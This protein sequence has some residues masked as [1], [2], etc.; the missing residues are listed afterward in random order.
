M[1]AGPV[2]KGKIPNMFKCII[3]DPDKRERENNALGLFYTAIS[4]ATTLGDHD[5]LGSAIYFD[6]LEYKEERIRNI[7]HCKGSL[8][9]YKKKKKR[10]IWTLYLKQNT[11]TSIY[12]TQQCEDILSWATNKKSSFIELYDRTKFYIHNSRQ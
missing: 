4:R 1:S 11:Q 3:C 10:D 6:G 8:A 7:G 12:T 5:G 9:D 2:D